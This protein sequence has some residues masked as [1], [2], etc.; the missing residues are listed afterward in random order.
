MLQISLANLSVEPK[1]ALDELEPLYAA[2]R[3]HALRT[4]GLRGFLSAESTCLSMRLSRQILAGR[5]R[6]HRAHYLKAEPH[7]ELESLYCYVAEYL[8]LLA[9]PRMPLAG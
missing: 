1:E 6:G 2:L 8:D 4:N 5:Y 3:E 9:P 7:D